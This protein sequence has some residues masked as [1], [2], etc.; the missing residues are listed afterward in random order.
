MAET[1]FDIKSSK[2][3]EK[4]PVVNGVHLHSIYNPTREAEGFISKN[5]ETIK[6]KKEILVLGLGFGYHIKELENR[7]KEFHK[8]NFSIVVIEPNRKIFQECTKHNPIESKHTTILAGFTIEELY[9]NKGLIEYLINKPGI[10]AHPASLNLYDQFFKNFLSYSAPTKIN[11]YVDRFTH[12][13][14]IAYF[15]KE[16]SKKEYQDKT[17]GALTIDRYI[18]NHVEKKSKLTDPIEWLLLGLKELLKFKDQISSTDN[19]TSERQKRNIKN[20]KSINH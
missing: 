9:Q 2:S 12:K 17:L 5:I 20:E 15:S 10:I 13:E 11:E 3:N 16:F 19:K 14:F 1:F 4:V 6:I 8:N 18:D 7:L